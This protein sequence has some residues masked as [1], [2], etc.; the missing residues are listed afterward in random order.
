[1]NNL[2]TLLNQFVIDPDNDYNNL[3]LAKYYHSIGQTASAVSYYTRTA[4]RTEDQTLMYACLLAASDCFHSQGC[5]NDSVKGLLQSAIALCPKRPEG[6]FLLSRFYERVQNWYDSYLISSIGIAV[7]D[8][9]CKPLPLIVDYPGKYGVLFEKAISSWH[10]G[11]CDESRDLLIDLK[12]NYDLDEI[13][14]RA[15]DNNLRTIGFGSFMLNDK[16]KLIIA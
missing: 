16:F 4:E 14:A 11:L 9:D 3:C 7:S 13:H 12:E 8:F 10:C 2:Q 5:R 15:V 1:M 6:Y